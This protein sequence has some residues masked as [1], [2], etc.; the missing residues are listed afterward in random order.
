MSQ[1]PACYLS[2]KCTHLLAEAQNF[3]FKSIAEALSSKS[4]QLLLRRLSIKSII[5]FIRIFKLVN[6]HKYAKKRVTHNELLLIYTTKPL[7][8]VL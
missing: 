4:T 3:T 2:F 8:S 1:F 5:N 6:L 7:C